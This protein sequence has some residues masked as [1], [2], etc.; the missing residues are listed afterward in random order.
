VSKIVRSMLGLSL[1]ATLA[2]NAPHAAALQPPVESAAAA[3]AGMPRDSERPPPGRMRVLHVPQTAVGATVDGALDDAAWKG[4]AVADRFWISEQERWPSEQ[5]EVLITADREY[6]YVGFK[7]YDSQPQAIQALQTRRSAGLGFDDQVAVELDPFLSYREISSYSVNANGVQDDAIT[8]GRARQLEW[9]GDWQAAAM[10]TAYG[11][12]AEIAIPF[13]ILNFEP[14]TTALGVN[15]LRYHHR[16]GQWSRWADITVRALP[17]EMGR[18]VGFELPQVARAQPWTLMPYALAGRNIPDKR[19][20]VR[21]TLVTAGAELRYQPRPNLTGVLSL[22]P[23]FSQVE[24][25]LTDINFSYNEKFLSDLRPF[26]QEGS[27]YFGKRSDYFYSNRIPDF[28]YGA[29]FFSRAGG[30]QLGALAT[31]GPQERSDYVVRAERE[32]DATH[33]VGGMVVG[34]EQPDLRN[35]LYMVRGQG[36]EPSGLNYAFEAAATSTELQPGDA[37][38]AAVTNTELQPGD[39]SRLAGTLG[40]AQDFWSIAVTADRYTL[41]YQP[42]NAL[43]ADDLPDTSGSLGSVNYFRDLGEGPV[44]EVQGNISLHYR[45]TG[46]GRLQRRTWNAGGTVESRAQVRIGLWYTA[47]PYRPVGATAGSWS[48][49]V[50][51]D[52]YWTASVDFNTRSSR[53]GYGA[54][55]SSGELGGGDYDY[56]IGYAFIRPTAVTFLSASSERLSNFGDFDQTIVVARWDISKR[57]SIAGRYVTADSGEAYRLAYALNLRKNLDFFLVYDREPVQLATLSAKII[58]TVQ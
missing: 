52:D 3:S 24:A 57:Q 47:G 56:L 9:K 49:T 2:A 48:D 14:G 20:N 35:W 34:S 55:M 25:A 11:W 5:T 40:W 29:K 39:G 10:R 21:E 58:L 17:E 6:L 38:D 19:G 51:D 42:L 43:L 44:R 27:A 12:S 7:V 23:D 32:F 16:T 1:A 30:Y 54:S 41:N 33:S 37:F 45:Q 31:R 15:F 36:R 46:D 53:L 26:F 4:A 8:G 50:N 18:L 13:S 22:N 28:D